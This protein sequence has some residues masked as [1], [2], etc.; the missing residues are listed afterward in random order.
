MNIAAVKA[1]HEALTIII[2]RYQGFR[3]VGGR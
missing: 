2:A 3:N 1:T